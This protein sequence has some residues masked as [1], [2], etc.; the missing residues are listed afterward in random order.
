MVAKPG[1]APHFF[2]PWPQ[3][4]PSPAPPRPPFPQCPAPRYPHTAGAFT[5][6]C[7]YLSLWYAP[8]CPQS[9]AAPLVSL[10]PFPGASP[11]VLPILPVLPTAA[12]RYPVLPAPRC[13]CSSIGPPDAPL[14]ILF[15]ALD[16][17]RC[18][19]RCA[20]QDPTDAPPSPHWCSP[21]L[22][23]AA[24]PGSPAGPL[25]C[26]PRPPWVPSPDRPPVATPG[27]PRAPLGTSSVPPWGSPVQLELFLLVLS[28]VLW[29][30]TPTPTWLHP[31]V[32]DLWRTCRIFSPV[33]FSELGWDRSR[34]DFWIFN[35]NLPWA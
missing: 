16:L 3:P 34:S 31:S 21:K 28:L 35:P 23:P 13:R 5:P 24:P 12:A 10:F 6:L 8:G 25:W 1:R 15:M 18:L 7:P 2:S 26:P 17:P 22:R 11:L 29:D 19:S 33:D 14:N 30:E 32:R 4:G 27:F 9:P 20:P